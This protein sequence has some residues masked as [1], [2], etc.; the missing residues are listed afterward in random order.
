MARRILILGLFAVILIVA[1]LTAA[2]QLLSRRLQ[3]NFEAWA[4]TAR[5][6]GWSVA[7]A[8]PSRTGWP[9]FASLDVPDFTI[10]GP[11]AGA[12]VWHSE[13]LRLNLEPLPP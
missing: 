6:Q 10:S 2:Q 7:F 5:S 11:G 3:T 12:P 8:A 13:R 4:E 1:G 9:R